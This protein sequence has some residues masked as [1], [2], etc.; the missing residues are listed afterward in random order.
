MGCLKKNII[1]EKILFEKLI[2]F[3]FAKKLI[4]FSGI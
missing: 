4:K 2:K 1:F 3:L